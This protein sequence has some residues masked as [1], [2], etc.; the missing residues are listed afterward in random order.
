M[1]TA[2]GGPLRPNRSATAREERYA[3]SPTQR[4]G[5]NALKDGPSPG[6]R[7]LD[8]IDIRC[9]THLCREI[10]NLICLTP[11]SRQA[12]LRMMLQKLARLNFGSSSA[13]TS[14]FMVP[15][16]VSGLWQDPL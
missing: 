9:S 14:S 3:Q 7:C 15:Q 6:F 12:E 2:L 16:V 5:G 8:F 4:H 1:L 10:S 11:Y 13:S